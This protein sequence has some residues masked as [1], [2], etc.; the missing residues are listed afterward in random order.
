M[1]RTRAPKWLQARRAG[2]TTD[3]LGRALG[4]AGAIP[5][6]DVAAALAADRVTVDG[7]GV[8]DPF[9]PVLPGGR[10]AVDGA[11]ASLAWRTRILAFHKPRGLVVAGSDPD[12]IGTVFDALRTALPADL[13]RFVWHAVGRLDRDTTGLLLFT[14]DERFVEHATAPAT[15]LPSATSRRWTATPTRRD[16]SRSATA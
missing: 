2:A 1:A 16:S 5:D 11:P 15:H 4:R 14:N 3:W 7:N 13:R 10:I 9:A 12:A 6:G 8:R